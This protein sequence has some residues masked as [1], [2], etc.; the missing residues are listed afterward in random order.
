MRRGTKWIVRLAILAVL[1]G[2]LAAAGAWW[3]WRHIQRPWQ[4]ADAPESVVVVVEPGQAVAGIF[5]ELER[6]RVIESAA[7]ARIYMRLA[8]PD[9]T[10]QAGEY[11]FE[12]P[13]A[14]PSVVDRLV[15]GDVLEHPV[16]VIEGLTRQETAETLARQGF[17]DLERLRTLVDDPSLVRDLDPEASSLEGYL[18]PDTYRFPRSATEEHIVRTMVETF[19]QRYR[20]A[21]ERADRSAAGMAAQRTVREVVTLASIVEK[22]AG[23][24]AERPLVAAVYHNRLEIGMALY[25][26]PTIIYA[27]KQAGRWDGNLR[28]PDLKLDSPYNTYVH[29]G[30]PPGPICSPGVESLAAAMAPADAP[31]LYFVSKNDGSH[32]FARTLREHNANVERWQRRYWRERWAKER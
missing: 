5:A 1:A 22:E 30:L 17:G 9:A 27:L 16:T 11:R 23:L 14:L 8:R 6:E 13:V 21:R 2:A 20:A 18:F 15:R 10:L 28:R 3:G 24:D 4:S 32:V 31:Y 7:A 26:D 25:A 29:A 19:R 12:P